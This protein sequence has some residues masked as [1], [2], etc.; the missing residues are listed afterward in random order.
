MSPHGHPGVGRS[1]IYGHTSHVKTRTSR[2]LAHFRTSCV[3]VISVSS[4]YTV[5]SVISL[6]VLLLLVLLLLLL[7]ILVMLLL[8]LLV[9]LFLEYLFVTV[10]T[11]TAANAIFLLK[12][13]CLFC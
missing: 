11:F 7:L 10:A 5:A 6:I 12:I 9:L 4:C 3:C 2:A 8:V 1:I 13:C